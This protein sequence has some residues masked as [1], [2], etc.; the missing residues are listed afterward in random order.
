MLSEISDTC[1]KLNLSQKQPDTPQTQA[2]RKHVA[3]V[4]SLTV[5]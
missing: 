3:I 5:K 4:F 2:Y 1:P